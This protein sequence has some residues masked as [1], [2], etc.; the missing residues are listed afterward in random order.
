MERALEASVSLSRYS[1]DVIEGLGHLWLGPPIG[2]DQ[3][4][5]APRP[6]FAEVLGTLGSIWDPFRGLLLSRPEGR[7]FPPSSGISRDW[8]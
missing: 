3:R 4:R 2:G 7:L 6:A 5:H 1:L 8:A